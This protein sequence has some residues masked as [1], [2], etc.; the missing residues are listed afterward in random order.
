[1]KK[2]ISILAVTLL[3]SLSLWAMPAR[4]DTVAVT[5]LDRM[6]A[7]MA[8]IK[9]GSVVVKS[10]Y[11]VATQELGLV[12]HADEE[13]LYWDA[14][15]KLYMS[16]EGDKGIR[17]FFYNGKTFTYYSFTKNQYAQ[18]NAP[19]NTIDMIDTMNRSY[20]IDFPAADYLYQSFVDDI[21]K[22][23]NSIEML[24]M[25]KVGGK[26]CF[27]IAGTSN[28]KTFQFWITEAPFYLPAKMVVVYTN[29]PM[30]PQYEA[31]Y[32]DWQINPVLPNSIFE[33]QTPPNAKKIKFSPVGKK[34]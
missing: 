4:I 2:H 14:T 33:F 25:V 7:L 10:N 23:A 22:E 17:N 32:N 24:G 12:K 5:V 15:N 13:H 34:N 19:T 8:D 27:H 9:S 31:T 20:G 28:D 26:N 1:M 3:S 30:R 18:T 29:D 21:L 16:A 11:D 6:S